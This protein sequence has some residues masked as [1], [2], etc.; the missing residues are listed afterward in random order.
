MITYPIA[1]VG[2]CQLGRQAQADQASVLHNYKA[3]VSLGN[4]QPLP[5]LFR[6]AGLTFPF[7]QLAVEEAVQFIRDQ[8]LKLAN[9]T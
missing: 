7:T 3:A 8:A 6:V 1:I 9:A 5:E 4:T 2:V